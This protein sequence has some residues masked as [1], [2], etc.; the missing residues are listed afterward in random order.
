MA[1]DRTR[2]HF[3]WYDLMTTDP[4]GAVDFYGKVVGWGR[5]TWDEGE[6][7][8][9][10]WTAGEDLIGGLVRLDD[11][12][13]KT[14][15]PH[16][17][18]YTTVPDTDAAV[19]KAKELG[20]QV[21]HGPV[22]VPTVGRFA[23][24]ADPHGAVFSVFTPAGTPPGPSGKLRPGH[25]S[26]HELATTDYNSAMDFYASLFAWEVT[27]DVDMGEM[28]TYRMY[29]HGEATYGGMYNKVQDDMPGP[30]FWLHYVLVDDVHTAVEGV[31]AHGGRVL[32]GPMEVPGG[33][34]V[35]PCMDPQGAL[36]ALHAKHLG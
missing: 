22:D 26:W 28:G 30:P 23:I 32:A 13:A 14:V 3:V 20:G 1:N 36:F 27:E 11:E 18:A 9:I 17:L 21:L 25:F 35:A 8:Y 4:A 5:K 33:D 2:G 12:T 15:P 7:A 24:L 19:E 31:R 29:G 6:D 34:H 16:W 10:M